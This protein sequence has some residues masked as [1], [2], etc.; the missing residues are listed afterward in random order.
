M[1]G[2]KL[3]PLQWR[4][5]RTLVA[6]DPPWVLT[7]GGA[8][9]GIHLMHRRTKDLDLFWHGRSDLGELPHHA[10]DRLRA[11]G[12]TVDVLQTSQSFHRL[13][14]TDESDACIVDLVAD[15]AGTVDD[16]IVL[17]TFGIRF[18]IDT[19]HEILV[20]K[21]CA[22]L[23]RSELRDLQDVKALM[24]SGQDLVRA[25]S[26]A[27]RKDAGFSPLTLAWVVKQLRIDIMARTLGLTPQETDELLTFQRQMVDRLT[28]IGAPTEP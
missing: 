1:S 2:D 24:E 23:G 11:N 9:A 14:V 18:S 28:A 15:P 17:E 10:I 22:L 7:G 27:P 8:L 5:L 20:N 26:D 3:S 12:L 6:L 25:L 13:R 4:I 21:L 16:P 19:P